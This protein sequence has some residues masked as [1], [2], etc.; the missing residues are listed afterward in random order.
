MPRHRT[1]KESLEMILIKTMQ[2]AKRVSGVLLLVLFTVT[3]FGQIPEIHAAT[4]IAF[5]GSGG[6]DGVGN[7]RREE[8]LPLRKDYPFELRSPCNFLLTANISW[9]RIRSASGC[10]N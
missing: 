9:Q 2:Q 5:V 4:R 6:N 10:W 1:A 7:D 8:I 3:A